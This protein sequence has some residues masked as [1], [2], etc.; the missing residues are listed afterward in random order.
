MIP[1]TTPEEALKVTFR[2]PHLYPK[3]ERALYNDARY[4]VVEASTK[5]GKTHGAMVWLFEQ[6]AMTG[7]PGR[8]YWWVAPVTQQAKIAYRRLKRAIP[9]QLRL[10]NESELFIQL[11]N[12]A[13]MYFKG[14]DRPDSLYGDDV[15]AA[16]ID[17]ASRCREDAWHAVR[18]TLTA[19]RGQI[20]IIGNVKGRRNWAYSIARV[21]ESGKEGY[22][23]HRINAWD[24]VEAG[25]LAQEEIEDARA[26]LPERVFRE[27]YLAEPGESEGR[28]YSNFC[29]ENL[30]V[31][32]ETISEQRV[33]V[34]M[35]FNVNP[36]TAVVGQMRGDQLHIITEIVQSNSNT[37]RMAATIADRWADHDVVVYPD[38]SGRARKTSS[39]STDFAI[40]EDHGLSVVAPKAAPRVEDRVNTVNAGFATSDGTRRLFVDS[41]CDELVKALWDLYYDD[42]GQPTKDTG[43]DHITDALGYLVTGVMPV[44]H[45][46]AKR[47]KAS[48]G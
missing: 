18:S 30:V 17:E 39:N 24:A 40:L 35:D 36:M 3:Q 34:G 37:Q 43:D 32:S 28:V 6:A 20:R 25:V 14:S 16:V 45:H 26:S 29:A 10:C 8:N 11:T 33:V 22:E 7:R 2:R 1:A 48:W 21:A 41:Q 38:P 5:S 47:V 4:S 27:L 15:K 13:L 42:K 9:E 19:T 31:D 44:T 46:R 12:G 23:Y